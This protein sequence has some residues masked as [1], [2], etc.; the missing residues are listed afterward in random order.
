M[1]DVNFDAKNILNLI[2]IGIFYWFPIHEAYSPS[3]NLGVGVVDISSNKFFRA[4]I[5]ICRFNSRK[6]RPGVFVLGLIIP[7]RAF[8]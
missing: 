1:V 5:Q 4:V 8:D 2:K 7:R 3:Q 6:T